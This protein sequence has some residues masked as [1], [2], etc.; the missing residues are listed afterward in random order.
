MKKGLLAGLL[1]TML[2][3]ASCFRPFACLKLPAKQGVTPSPTVQQEPSTQGI[4]LVNRATKIAQ[5]VGDYD[6][7]RQEPTLNLTWSR[8]KLMGTDLGVPFKHKGRT[9]L[10]FGDTVGIRGGD[11]IAYTTDTT[12]EDGLELTFLHDDIGYKPVKIPGISQGG[13]E[14]PMEGVSVG[15]KM[16]IYHT[17]DSMGVTEMFKEGEQP[18]MGRSVVAV[19]DD[20]GDT[21]TYLY[22]FSTKH[23]INVSIVETDEADLNSY[24]PQDSGKVLVIFGSGLYRRSDVRLAF[25]PSDQ[26]KSHASIRYFAGLD[27]SGKP[28]LSANEDDAQALFYQPVVGELSVTYNSFINKWIMLYNS[29]LP[30]SRGINIRVADKPWGPWSENQVIFEP[31]KDNGYCHFMHAGSP[32]EKCDEVSDPNREKEYGGEYGPYQFDNL[33]IGNSSTATTTIYFTMSTWNP[34]TVVLMK[35]TLRRMS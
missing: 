16:Y 24:F 14:V 2:M 5:L 4:V 17:T 26:I 10:L 25:Q 19:S 12:P 20:D 1:V 21:F 15:G 27:S 33:A 32:H 31:W 11:A 29:F 34:Y 13:F 3:C 28:I 8:Y 23:F 30:T 9:Y 35:A 18:T 6:R 7:E 22:D